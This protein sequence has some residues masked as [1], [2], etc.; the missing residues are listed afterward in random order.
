[1]IS[2]QVI[3]IRALTSIMNK[4][5]SKL[6]NFRSANAKAVVVVDR[7]IQK[8]FQQEGKLAYPGGGWQKLSP[9]TIAMRRKGK[10][11]KFGDKILQDTGR[12]RNEWKKQ[13]TTK[14]GLIQ[15]SMPYAADHEFGR[16]VPERRI[17]PTEPQIMPELLKVYGKHV[18]TS[19]NA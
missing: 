2:L 19:L 1:M 5:R 18:R 16:G 13:W 7:W 17:L 14:S 12:L 4:R 8:N 10:K 3:G 11:S 15:A 6:A 9:A